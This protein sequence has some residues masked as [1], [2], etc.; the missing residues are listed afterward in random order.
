MLLSVSEY[1][2]VVYTVRVQVVGNQLELMISSSGMFVTITILTFIYLDA[3]AASIIINHHQSSSIIM[4]ML[5][6]MALSPVV[7][8]ST[9]SLDISED[10]QLSREESNHV[11][12]VIDSSK[13]M[14]NYPCRLCL[15]QSLHPNSDITELA[16]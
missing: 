4:V 12:K 2:N 16:Q 15:R 13:N 10:V 9:L 8:R 6:P 7:I 11:S 3:S 14:F 1:C 5:L